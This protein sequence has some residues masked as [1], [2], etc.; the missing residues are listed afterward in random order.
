MFVS[1]SVVLSLFFTVLR[2]AYESGKSHWLVF[3]LCGGSLALARCLLVMQACRGLD[4]GVSVCRVVAC[5]EHV[6]QGPHLPFRRPEG[7]LYGFGE[8]PEY[9]CVIPPAGGLGLRIVN[10]DGATTDVLVDIVAYVLC[11]CDV[12]GEVVDDRADAWYDCEATFC[13]VCAWSSHCGKQVCHG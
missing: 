10:W 11:F 7:W 3:D 13:G 8:V 5:G 12:G 4:Y 1:S 6:H 2:D 9:F